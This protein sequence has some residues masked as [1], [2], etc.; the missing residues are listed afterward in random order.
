MIKIIDSENNINFKMDE[1]NLNLP[2]KFSFYYKISDN[3]LLGNI[4]II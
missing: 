1:N 3:S 2:E 4:G